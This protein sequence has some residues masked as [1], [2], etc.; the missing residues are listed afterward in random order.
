MRQTDL[1]HKRNESGDSGSIWS[2][3]ASFNLRRDRE[4][5][6]LRQ[7]LRWHKA[8]CRHI[9]A[10]QAT[11]LRRVSR[12]NRCMGAIRYFA[13]DAQPNMQRPWPRRS[14]RVRCQNHVTEGSARLAAASRQI[15]VGPAIRKHG[16]LGAASRYDW[17]D[18][19]WYHREDAQRN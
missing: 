12:Q 13:K 17:E 1:A 3:E 8:L 16:W 4:T 11:F 5:I 14:A 9:I 10:F 19:R 15:R 2:K 7:R 6:S 18:H